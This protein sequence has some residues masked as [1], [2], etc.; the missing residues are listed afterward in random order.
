MFLYLHFSKSVYNVLERLI[1][2][3]RNTRGHREGDVV[4]VHSYCKTILGGFFVHACVCTCRE[5]EGQGHVSS[6]IALYVIIRAGPGACSPGP[7]LAFPPSYG[8]IRVSNTPSFL[9]GW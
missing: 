9:F 7:F 3:D 4:W 6:S 5:A 1:F 8:N 2:I